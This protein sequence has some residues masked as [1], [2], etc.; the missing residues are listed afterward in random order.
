MN[1]AL[2]F[3]GKMRDGSWPMNVSKSL[4]SFVDGPE[5]FGCVYADP[6]WRYGNQ[7]TRAS[8]DR[9]YGTMSV[10]EI[11]DL[12]I[13]QIVADNAH[14][15]LWTTNAFLFDCQKIMTSWGFEYKSCFVW[16]KPRMGIGNYWRVSHEFLLFGVRGDCPFMARN[17]MSWAN[18]PRGR[19]SAKPDRIRQTIERVSPAPRIELFARDCFDGWS[20]WGNQMRGNLFYRIEHE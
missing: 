5:K 3:C 11:A 18:I 10:E 6:P 16:V 9:H 19:H 4:Q 13:R 2:D 17:E 20:A 7:A 1:L 14:L 12:P 8:T 15:H